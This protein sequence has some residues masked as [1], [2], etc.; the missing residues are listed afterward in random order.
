MAGS[1][2]GEG[3]APNPQPPN[4]P[5]SSTSP[6]N[7]ID[8]PNQ[9]PSGNNDVAPDVT[10]QQQ[11]EG[12]EHVS[13][14]EVS[15]IV[16]QA[17]A[18]SRRDE[19]AAN[20]GVRRQDGRERETRRP[21]PLWGNDTTP[22]PTSW[23]E[24]L[25]SCCIP[26]PVGGAGP[27][28][29]PPSRDPAI[30][31][32]QNRRNPSRAPGPRAPRATTPA[33]GAAKGQ[34]SSSKA[35]PPRSSETSPLPKAVKEVH[36]TGR[37]EGNIQ[38]DSNIHYGNHHGHQTLTL[39]FGGLAHELATLMSKQQ[40][41]DT[42]K[43]GQP[44]KPEGT[45]GARK[46]PAPRNNKTNV[47]ANKRGETRQTARSKQTGKPKQTVK[48][49]QTVKTNQQEPK[50]QGEEKRESGTEQ[51]A[52]PATAEPAAAGLGDGLRGGLG[53]APEAAPGAAPED[54][55][56]DT[57]KDDPKNDSETESECE[58][59]N[60]PGD[61]SDEVSDEDAEDA[62]D[63]AEE[64]ADGGTGDAAGNR[65]DDEAGNGAGEEAGSGTKSDPK[66]KPGANRQPKEQKTKPRNDKGNA[67]STNN[68]N[69]DV[70]ADDN[71][72]N[73]VK[74]GA[75]PNTTAKESEEKQS[76]KQQQSQKKL[77]PEPEPKPKSTHKP[78]RK[79][80]TNT[81]KKGGKGEAVAT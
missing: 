57:T 11:E 59:N 50:D 21:P 24:E 31:L 61:V 18:R 70:D 30:R 77:E 60:G 65:T 81:S 25:I 22:G 75:S 14:D 36:Y 58:A 53:D 20:R 55:H 78:T 54:V 29:E 46:P 41:Q 35:A 27:T 44:G 5:T 47:K 73:D 16:A 38:R 6:A 68:A 33:T 34:S 39:D 8:S 13:R 26:W 67:V 45:E 49:G 2:T 43:A 9:A 51:A 7:I 23:I 52:Q 12:Q 19:D 56:G 37:N 15:E 17:F 79:R 66:S 64:N 10:Q 80:Q 48:T 72:G 71:H 28:P 4:E 42:S 40:S 69:D 3:S 62:E 76:Q 74:N 63:D 32:R 1:N